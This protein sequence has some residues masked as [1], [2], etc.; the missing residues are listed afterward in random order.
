MIEAINTNSSSEPTQLMPSNCNVFERLF[1]PTPLISR[2]DAENNLLKLS[3]QMEASL[4]CCPA[5]IF[6]LHCDILPCVTN[7]RMVCFVY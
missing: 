6:A 3:R 7:A 5:S 1:L 2:M 4:P